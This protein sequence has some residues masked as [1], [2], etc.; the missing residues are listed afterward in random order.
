MGSAPQQ[1]RDARDKLTHAKLLGQIVVRAAL[2]TKD[3][4]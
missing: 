3:L 1:S 4:V 2:E